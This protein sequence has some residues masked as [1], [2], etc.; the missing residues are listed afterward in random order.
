MKKFGILAYPAKH[1]F[2]PILHAAAFKAQRIPAE[3][4]IFEVKP[5]EFNVFISKLVREIT[6]ISVSLPYKEKI[7]ESLHFVEEEARE[8]GA[9][10]T[11]LNKNGVL[12][13]Y[14][15]DYLGVV[16]AL[17]EK[18]GSLRGKSAVVLGAG[19]AGRA[20]CYG[21]LK[22]GVD[23]FILNRTKSRADGL[24]IEFA[25]RFQ[26]KIRSA[27]M[28]KPLPEADIL[29]NASSYWFDLE[30][31]TGELPGFF[32]PGSVSRFETVMDISYNLHLSGYDGGPLS[33]P[34]T[35][36]AE[37]LSKNVITGEKML[38]YQALEQFKIWT[39]KE[40]PYSVMENALLE[41]L[42]S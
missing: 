8:I 22:S 21:L 2:S 29:I 31:F 5:A 42:N 17:R 23:V 9:V 25:E 28:E 39:G 1:S 41:F 13:G 36:L 4:E 33:T 19:G 35:E 7:L 15:T 12:H 16:K 6:G 26:A 3:Y 34:L 27:D 11:V 20:I 30:N 38:I 32:L 40:V 14:N 18:I 24:A 37:N 10:N